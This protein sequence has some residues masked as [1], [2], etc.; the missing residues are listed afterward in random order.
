MFIYLHILAI[1]FH[2][3]GKD[4]SSPQKVFSNISEVHEYE[5]CFI[6]SKQSEKKKQIN[7]SWKCSSPYA[8]CFKDAASPFWYED[9]AKS[10][11]ASTSTDGNREGRLLVAVFSSKASIRYLLRKNSRKLCLTFPHRY[12]HCYYRHCFLRHWNCQRQRQ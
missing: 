12:D 11:F 4:K 7:T 2:R 10:F 8:Y 9:F 5:V 1:E 6:K 3:S